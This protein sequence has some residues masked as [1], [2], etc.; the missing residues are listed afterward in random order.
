MAI[1]ACLRREMMKT[2]NRDGPR[3]K[4]WTMPT[5]T[6][7]ARDAKSG[8]A[9]NVRFEPRQRLEWEDCVVRLASCREGVLRKFISSKQ[10][11]SVR[12]VEWRAL[13]SSQFPQLSLFNNSN[14]FVNHIHMPSTDS[15]FQ[16]VF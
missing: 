11:K 5:R 12:V 2:T 10:I 14:F 4:I 1:W 9:G 6:G 16:Y 8:S 13:T 15:C 7:A 3:K